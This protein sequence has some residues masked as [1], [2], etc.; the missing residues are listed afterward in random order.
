MSVISSALNIN[1]LL[2]LRPFSFCVSPP[3]SVYIFI[4]VL[5]PDSGIGDVLFTQTMKTFTISHISIEQQPS[6]QQCDADIS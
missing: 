1:A 6:S 5:L 3:T 4:K 2:C